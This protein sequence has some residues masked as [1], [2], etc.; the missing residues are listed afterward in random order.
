[1]DGVTTASVGACT[2]NDTLLAACLCFS[3]KRETPVF[4]MPLLLKMDSWV[5]PLFQSTFYWE[6]KCSECKNA[7]KER[8]VLSYLLHSLLYLLSA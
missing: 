1:M 2:C 4:A 6:F 7:T 5:E 3:G 8:L